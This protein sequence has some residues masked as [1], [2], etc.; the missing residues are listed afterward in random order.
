MQ[1]LSSGRCSLFIKPLVEDDKVKDILFSHSTWDEYS[2]MIR[3]IKKYNFEFK[4]KKDLN[5]PNENVIFT[6][7]PG[8]IFKKESL[9]PQMIFI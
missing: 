4:G 6:S 2:E 5:F 9:Y 7:Y 1:I 8:A 3:I